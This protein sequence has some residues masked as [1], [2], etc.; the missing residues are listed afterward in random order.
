MRFFRMIA[1]LGY[2]GLLTLLVAK[3][4]LRGEPSGFPVALSLLIFV[5]PLLLP[6]RGLL[7]GRPESHL[8]AT[9]LALFYFC[10]G[11]FNAAGDP[12]QPWI[13]ALEITLS[14]LLFLGAL[15]YLRFRN[16]QRTAGYPTT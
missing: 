11:V 8:W 16:R 13:P 12:A 2:F 5:G 9:F 4:T 7:H 10:A 14:V 6:L 15:L 3:F 1:L